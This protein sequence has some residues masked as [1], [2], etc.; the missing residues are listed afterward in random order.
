MG[1]TYMGYLDEAG[2]HVYRKQVDQLAYVVDQLINNPTNRRIIVSA[3]NPGEL[4]MM[5]LPPC[6]AFHQYNCEPLQFEDRVMLLDDS[7]AGT[8]FAA[9]APDRSKVMDA[10]GIPKYR[11]N[12]MTYIRSNDVFLGTPFN[13]TSYAIL[14]KIMCRITGH[15]PGTLHY[16]TGDTHIYVQH[17]DGVNE[18]LDRKPFENKVELKIAD[19]LQTL[20]DFE[21][22]TP[23]DFELVNYKHHGKLISPTP[24]AI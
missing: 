17:M 2:L 5:A 11:L 20:E 22:A 12:M 15:V 10:L 1:Y 16:I 23:D 13:I 3:W 19:H 8:V 9:S 18:Q 7:N 6:H 4:D 21:K 14:L 24:M